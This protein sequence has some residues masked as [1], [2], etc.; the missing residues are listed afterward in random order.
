LFFESQNLELAPPLLKQKAERIW[1][2]EKD[3]DKS[4]STY[5]VS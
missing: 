4:V 5:Q 2:E 1:N 3:G